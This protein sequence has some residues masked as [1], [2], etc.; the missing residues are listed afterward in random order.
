MAAKSLPAV[1]NRGHQ[2]GTRAEALDQ[3]AQLL[4]SARALVAQVLYAD[5][6]LLVVD[7]ALCFGDGRVNLQRRSVVL[8]RP[9]AHQRLRP[10]EGDCA[11][12]YEA[13]GQCAC[14]RVYSVLDDAVNIER[15]ACDRQQVLYQALF[16]QAHALALV[17]ALRSFGGFDARQ[18]RGEH[19]SECARNL[20]VAFGKGSRVGRAYDNHAEH[21]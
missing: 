11:E 4:T 2:Y 17:R 3:W 13:R 12:H 10:S 8:R 16:T 14:E 18:R 15:R 20:R 9:R 21:A 1:D 6:P 19:G 7:D 5:G